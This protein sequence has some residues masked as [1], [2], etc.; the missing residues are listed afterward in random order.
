MNSSVLLESLSELVSG[1]AVE[2]VAVSHWPK[3]IF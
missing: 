1:S 3:I 2:S